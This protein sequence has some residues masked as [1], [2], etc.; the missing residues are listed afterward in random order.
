MR[1]LVVDKSYLDGLNPAAVNELCSK[2]Q[3][4]MTEE[5][6]FEL[7]T[8]DD[9][10]RLRAFRK[11]PDRVDPVSLIPNVGTLLRYEQRSGKPSAPL[12]QH[13][14]SE[15]FRFNARLRDGTFK[16]EG[17]YADELSN[18]R[19]QVES[20]TRGFI[21][22]CFAV[23][24]FFPEFMGVKTSDFPEVLK[25]A[26]CSMATDTERV[27][28]VYSL[29]V[30]A[31]PEASPPKPETID[32]RWAW[33]RWVQVQLIAA[34]RVFVRYQGKMPEPSTPKFWTVAEHTLLDSYYVL[35]GALSGALASR[36]NEIKDD[37][38]LL[39]PDG[40]LLE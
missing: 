15:S 18:F 33:F 9:Q 29:L 10:K 26:R 4:L 32:A 22:R 40:L 31:H 1:E 17:S 38:R 34:L 19:Q 13:R 2:Y 28:G 27:R 20:S 25:S 39:C 6:F 36:D 11:L 24:E 21:E 30:A 35:F 5:L 23:Q 7:I 37:F 8:T 12:H 3:V 14:I 16:F